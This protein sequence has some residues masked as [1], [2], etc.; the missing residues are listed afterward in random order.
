LFSFEPS[1]EDFFDH[2]GGFDTGEL[3]VEALEF[4]GEAVVVDAEEVE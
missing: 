3:H 2:F 1:G 4:F